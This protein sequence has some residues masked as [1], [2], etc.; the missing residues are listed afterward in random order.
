MPQTKTAPASF[1]L[2]KTEL[3]LYLDH[4]SQSATGNYIELDAPK[5]LPR[6]VFNHSEQL[7]DLCQFLCS[8]PPLPMR[9]TPQYCHPPTPGCCGTAWCP[10]AQER[11]YTSKKYHKWAGWGSV[12]SSSSISPGSNATTKNA[13]KTVGLPSTL[14]MHSVSIAG[15]GQEGEGWPGDSLINAGVTTEAV[16]SSSLRGWQC[17][18]LTVLGISHGD[19]W[20]T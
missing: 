7:R 6:H 4:L 13:Y 3:Y 20:A 5:Q 9:W 19:G 11:Y 16:T 14:S 18:T 1:A 2:I 10:A 15:D 17:R 12:S 8:L